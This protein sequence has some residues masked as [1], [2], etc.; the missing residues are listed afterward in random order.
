MSVK[1]KTLVEDMKIIPDANG[2]TNFRTP[3]A[4]CSYAFVFQPRPTQ[5]GEL[6]YQICLIFPKGK[7]SDW[8]GAV[9]A[10]A[11]AAA[12]KF[13]DNVAK[14][15]IN[16][17]CPIRDGDEER[18]NDEYKGNYFINAGNKNKPGIINRKGKEITDPEELYS[19]CY[20]RAALAFYPFN[21]EG[22]KG[23]G[24]GLNN[25]LFW[26]DGERLAGG[27]SADQEFSDL[28]DTSTEDDDEVVF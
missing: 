8:T 19:G 11:N 28:I 13:G 16:L 2:N 27:K 15:P 7:L 20:V 4:R 1:L 3:V 23:V 5:S 10:I 25:L 24:T 6:K 17:K 18:D 26:E 14:W 9:Q 21:V 22:N 12:K